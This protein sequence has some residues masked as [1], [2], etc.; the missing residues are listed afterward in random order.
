MRLHMHRL[1]LGSTT[2]ARFRS[3]G[4]G[5]VLFVHG[6]K[7]RDCV[8]DLEYSGYGASHDQS[9]SSFTFSSIIEHVGLD[10]GGFMYEV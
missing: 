3:Y 2:L 10:F 8:Y 1:V 7:I 9:F 5:E 6:I 4:I